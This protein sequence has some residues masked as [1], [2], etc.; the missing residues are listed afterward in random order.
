MIKFHLTSLVYR[1]KGISMT[2]VY[3]ILSEMEGPAKGPWY[4]TWSIRQYRP[5]APAGA[6]VGY[7]GVIKVKG[8]F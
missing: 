4:K 2:T 3:L 1:T 6:P 8:L 5:R 7:S